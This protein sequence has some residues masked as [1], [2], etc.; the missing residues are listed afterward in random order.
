MSQN[1]FSEYRLEDTIIRS[2][3]VLKYVE[4]TPV[5]REVLPLLLE[6]QDVVIKSQT[7]S[8]KT[9]AFGIPL[10]QFVAWEERA[11]QALVLTPTRE[12][13]MQIKEEIFNIGRYKR[14][15][16]EALFGKTSFQSQV[17]SLKQRTHVVV[18]T[19]GRLRD[20]IERGTI[21]LSQIK[22]LIIDEAD[23]M[24]AMGFIDQVEEILWELPQERTTALFSATMPDAVKELTHHFLKYPKFVE[25]AADEQSKKRIRQQ[26][27]R[28]EE[29]E[30]LATLRD[31]F[32][33]DNPDSSILFCNTQVMVE[34]L[35][36]E[37]DRAGIKVDMLHGGMDQKDRTHVMNDFKRGYFRHLVATDV[38]ARGI[39]VSD[40]AL[41]VNYDLPDK[42]E[43][44]VHRIGRT[45]RFENKGKALSLVNRRDTRSF[46]A[47]LEA[48]NHSLEEIPR[49]SRAT[50]DKYRLAFDQKQRKNPMLRKEIG[51]EFKTDIMK[52]H[53]NA[54]K[55][56][57][58]RPGDVVG[59]LCNIEGITGEDIGVIHLMDVSTFVEIL[60][61]KGKKALN[62][63]QKM[64]I[65]GRK[66]RVSR[67]N[68]T[69][70]ERHLRNGY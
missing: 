45:A 35:M 9:A 66:R 60:N 58:M 23:E 10:A 14:L 32:V 30:K 52:I 34:R 13:A 21:D 4:P 18:A 49:P 12:L 40:I 6:K 38:A 59:A 70:Y 1:K 25:I 54:G 64:P 51:L 69:E 53:I 57:K 42:T 50:V 63:L 27:I 55:K 67:S 24:F 2:L 29:E 33:V 39:D 22:T 47:I 11:P 3:T 7:G 37:L 68:E 20:H 15:K 28:V 61:G 65:K 48:Q 8:G 36:K 43:T 19:P 5:Q 56:T 44:Y 31:L 26:F 62:A 16:V 46:E 17:K 41:V